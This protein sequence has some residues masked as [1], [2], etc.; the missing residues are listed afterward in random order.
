M[1]LSFLIYEIEIVWNRRRFSLRVTDRCSEDAIK[2]VRSLY[3][4][5]KII[6]ISRIGPA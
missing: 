5:C 1:R 2:Y 6:R 4:D 3:P